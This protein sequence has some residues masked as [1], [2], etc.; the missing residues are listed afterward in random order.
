MTVQQDDVR[1]LVRTFSYRL[2]QLLSIADDGIGAM[3]V[4]QELGEQE[5]GELVVFGDEDK[6]LLE[7]F[8]FRIGACAVRQVAQLSFAER[9]GDGET[10]FAIGR[11]VDGD[12]AA[13]SLYF[14]P[15]DIK[16]ETRSLD[17]ARFAGIE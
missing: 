10:C 15:D 7:I 13:H 12:R 17:M 6:G 16:T 5:G 11:A 8:G 4:T 2:Q 9:Q 1:A 14:R 3:H